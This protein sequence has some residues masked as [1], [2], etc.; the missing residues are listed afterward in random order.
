MN[1]ESYIDNIRYNNEMNY[2][3]YMKEDC[4]DETYKNYISDVISY[5]VHSNKPKVKKKNS[6]NIQE[7]LAK[8]DDF[9]YKR[10]WKKL[11]KI[12]KKIKLNEYLEKNLFNADEENLNEIKK[13]LRN[14]FK[15]NKL[16]SAKKIFYD[17]LSSKILGINGLDYNP[18]T[19][20]YSYKK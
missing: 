2:L 3:K 6:N 12:H 19:N 16:N 4:S 5:K 10:P 20:K 13:L 14:E 1:Y 15:N 8:I 17:A 7:R 11:D 18:E 9:L